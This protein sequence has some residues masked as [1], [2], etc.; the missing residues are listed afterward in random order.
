VEK[1]GR[2]MFD[3]GVF[4]IQIMSCLIKSALWLYAELYLPLERGAHF[5]K[6]HKTKLL[7]NEND[8]WKVKNGA[9]RA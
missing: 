2:E 3:L 5:Q 1:T 8:G 6:D 7:K 4:E 9:E